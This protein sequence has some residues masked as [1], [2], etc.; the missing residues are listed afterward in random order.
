VTE[1]FNKYLLSTY[2]FSDVIL[3]AVDTTM[4]EIDMTPALTELKFEWEKTYNR[5]TK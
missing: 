1:S 3:D 2:Y 5:W 4:N